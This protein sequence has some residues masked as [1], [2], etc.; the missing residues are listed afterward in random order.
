MIEVTV[1]ET[2]IGAY[3]VLRD[4]P[5]T[6]YTIT[7]DD[8]IKLFDID[9]ENTTQADFV[10]HVVKMTEKWTTYFADYKIT[11]TSNGYDQSEVDW[12]LN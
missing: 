3:F 7:M 2:D 1:V 8:V 5:L 6:C 12:C 10:A 11:I 9:A 4:D